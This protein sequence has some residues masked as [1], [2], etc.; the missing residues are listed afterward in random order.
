MSEANN[1]L[2]LELRYTLGKMEVA[3][4]AIKEAI[5]WTD[6]NGNIQW[7]NAAFDQLAGMPHIEILGR[8]VTEV[9]PLRERGVDLPAK[10]HPVHVILDKQKDAS[11]YYEFQSERQ[12]RFL[13][14]S[15]QFIPLEPEDRSAVLVIRDITEV[16]HLEQ[17]HL[18]SKA[19]EA[20][21]NAIC[22]TDRAGEVIWINPAFTK[23]TGF[24][25]DEVYGRRLSFLKSGRHGREFYNNLWS[26]ISAGNVWEG[27]TINRKKNG[28]LYTEH[29][30]ITP[31][32][33]HKLQITH[34]IAIKQDVSDRKAAEEELKKHKDLL[35]QK[36]AER[37]RELE[38][39]QKELVAR[40]IETGRAQW[41]AMMLHNIGNAITPIETYIDGILGTETEKLAEYLGKCY[42]D[43]FANT[44]SLQAYVTEDTRGKKVL[45]YMGELI[46]TLKDSLQ[47]HRLHLEK[48]ETAVNYIGDILTLQQ[49][50]ASGPR[51]NKEL[52]NLN[53][54]IRD[55]LTMQSA[56]LQK[57]EIRV[58]IQ[59][60]QNIQPILIDKS[61]L[62]QVF[63]NLLK[64]SCEAIDELAR[65]GLEVREKTVAL[66]SFSTPD[67]VVMEVVD[68]GIGLSREEISQLFELGHSFKG[69]SGIGLYYCQQFIES[70]NGE[71]TVSSSGIGKGATVSVRFHSRPRK[72]ADTKS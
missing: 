67:A 34:F 8:P 31:V 19:L 25:L 36:V 4:G 30:I 65:R 14:I 44:D 16:K 28:A 46:R 56:A 54:L 2:E 68:S 70:N 47:S 3:L 62:I 12:V 55:A 26:T 59:L 17:V 50:Y 18:Q 48:I 15:G 60:N 64:N 32:L 42:E 72:D 1:E 33:N 61:R 9:M 51:E 5:V 11:G 35:E 52:V 38:N 27:E 29:Q 63:V 7:C 45:A 20:A 71:I 13:E 22:I 6:R 10:A 49:S 57:R 58:E 43:L 21:A 53:Q 66:R 69:S 24:V 41:S 37:T 40:A 23:L 39:A